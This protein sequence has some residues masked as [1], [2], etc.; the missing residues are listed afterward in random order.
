MSSETEQA[1]DVRLWLV[2]EQLTN[3][4]AMYEAAHRMGEPTVL[5]QG[6]NTY[7]ALWPLSKEDL[8]RIVMLLVWDGGEPARRAQQIITGA[9]ATGDLSV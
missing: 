2:T 4:V 6:G 9:L 5:A 1:R 7:R 3:D 8:E